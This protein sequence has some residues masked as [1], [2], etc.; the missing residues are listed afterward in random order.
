MVR[1]MYALRTENMYVQV[2]QDESLDICGFNC[3]VLGKLNRHIKHLIT[4][5]ALSI[6]IYIYFFFY[7]ILRQEMARK[8]I[9][10]CLRMIFIFFK[11]WSSIKYVESM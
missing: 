6:Y 1:P 11:F 2:L 4:T 3:W 8:F 5:Y 9:C 10:F 7:I